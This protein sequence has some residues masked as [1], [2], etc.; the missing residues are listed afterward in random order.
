MSRS[1]IDTDTLTVNSTLTWQKGL[2]S[3]NGGLQMDQID[4]RYA[5]GKTSIF[6][7]YVYVN[8]NRKL[9]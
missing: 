4:T 7:N 9:F 8:V 5:T 1:I 3:V 2:L 6:S